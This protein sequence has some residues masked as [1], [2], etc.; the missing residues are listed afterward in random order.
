LKVSD[1]PVVKIFILY[2]IGFLL[3]YLVFVPSFVYLLVL[4][5]LAIPVLIFRGRKELFVNTLVGLI[6]ITFGAFVFSTKFYRNE[7]ELKIFD[8]LQK[9]KVLIYGEVSKIEYHD[10]EKIQF[11]LMADTLS[12]RKIKIPINQNLLVNLDLRESSFSLKYFEKIISIGNRI[13]ISGTLSKPA[14]SVY[15]GEFDLRLYLKS[16]N[17]DYILQSNNFDELNLIAEKSSI[18]NYRKYLS[19]LRQRIKFQIEENFDLLHAAYIKGLFI[20]ERTDIPDEVKNNFVNSGVIH[21]LAVSGLHT[22]YIA[23]ILFGLFGRFNLAIKII[24]VSFG[25]FVFAH[26]ANLS[27]SVVRASLMSVIVLLGMLTQRKGVLLNSISIAGLIILIINPLDVFNPSF[28]LSFSA[29][30][31][32][33]LIYPVLND[34]VKKFN[35]SG[36]TKLILDLLLISIAVSIGTFPFVA[37]YYQKFS[38]ISL[39]A[40]LIVIPLTGIILGG[41]ILN[42]VV[43]NLIPSL[44]PIYKSFL[45]TLIEFNFNV[46]DFFGNLPFAYTTIRNFSLLN[47]IA[48]YL[49]IAIVLVII[50]S[51]FNFVF[52]FVTITLLVF[53]YVYHYDLLDKNIIERDKNYIMVSKMSNSNAILFGSNE[54]YFLK[55]FERSDSLLHTRKD[56]NKLNQIVDRLNIKNFNYASFSTQSIFLNNELRT[57]LDQTRI[58]RLSD[59]IWLFGNNEVEDF[60]DHE[61]HNL[62]YYFVRDSF[63]EIVATSDMHLIISP[64][65]IM[66]VAEKFSNEQVKIIW[67]NPKLDTIFY[68]INSDNLNFVSLNFENQRMKIFEFNNE[69]LK[70]IK[71]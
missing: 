8:A 38:F 39:I 5:V 29:V 13:R 23:L 59:K 42:L 26:I 64:L 52:K 48:Y 46:V 4:I 63:T 27:P 19:N 61:L 17:I 51:K 53:N 28:Q 57:K 69:E 22:G 43:L 9:R 40:N 56:L 33:A 55:I 7:T 16:K 32:I 71:W 25:L 35:I 41:I 50:K 65:N 44:F 1:Y 3:S 14:A 67:V 47:S 11:H 2:L 21:V 30:L 34:Y 60:D 31:S 68:R 18:F 54:K 12:Y 49:L 62:R 37:S 20:A 6:V 36:F 24:L 10:K 58:K 70:E 45:V 66:K 15:P